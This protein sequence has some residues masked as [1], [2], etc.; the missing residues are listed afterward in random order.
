M[1]RLV[2]SLIV[3][4]GLA[5]GATAALAEYPERTINM[6]VPFGA[7]G[8][9]DVPARFFA[10]EMEQILG[11]N[12]VISNV[13]GAGGTIGATQ[14]SQADADGYNLGFMPVGTTTTQ[15]H[16]KR[17]S[18]NAD[19]W[20]PICMVSQ[21]PFYLV[22]A[23]DSAIQSIEDYVAR[24]NG[25]G[26]KFAGAG[27]G[28]MAHV[29]QLTVDNALGVT[30]RY[31][32]TRGGGDIATEINGGRAD[33]TAWFADFGTRFGWRAL[34]ILSDQ[35]SDAHPDVPTMAELGHDAQVSVWFGFFTQA[36]TPDEI[37][38][39]LSNA[40]AQAVATDSFQENMAGANRL[41]RYMGTEEF[42]PF[43]REAYE[44]NGQL[45]EEAGLVQ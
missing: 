22:V 10:S 35:R 16:L 28:S 6:L 5:L 9:T 21:G 30:T 17:T 3:G 37:V 25:D 45:L 18:Y 32:P 29:A 40:C 2:T 44:L 1:K 15:P 19:S 13:D 39:T 24:A 14:L 11:Q 38:A 27:P 8:G 31:I 36:G 41:I 12:I 43:F 26:V 33:A 34:A 23:E 42:G 7:G 4:G 20:T